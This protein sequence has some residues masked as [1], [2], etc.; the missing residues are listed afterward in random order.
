MLLL[1]LLLLLGCPLLPRHATPR[2]VMLLPSCVSVAFSSTVPVPIP[3]LPSLLHPAGP[4]SESVSASLSA[5]ERQAG[6]RL[7]STLP[8]R[9]LRRPHLASDTGAS[10]SSVDGSA[11]ETPLSTD[12]FGQTPRTLSGAGRLAGED[13]DRSAPTPRTLS[14]AGGVAATDPLVAPP[15]PS[16]TLQPALQPASEH[17]RGSGHEPGPPTHTLVQGTVSVMS[18]YSL[19]ETVQRGQVKLQ[20]TVQRGQVK[21]QETVQRG[22]VKLR[23]WAAGLQDKVQHWAAAGVGGLGVVKW[24]DHL[25]GRL[26]QDCRPLLCFVNL[27]SGPQVGGL[28][29]W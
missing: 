7:A 28:V 13:D 6:A 26:P 24:R 2:Q 11:Q 20:E 12:G 18:S 27:K 15:P 19:Q 5:S 8:P 4:P 16:S 25:I 10:D 22:Q 14:G 9:P 23:H 1:L 3:D 17:E 29:L 21:L